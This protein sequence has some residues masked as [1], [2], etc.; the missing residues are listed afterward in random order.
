MLETLEKIA[1]YDNCEQ[2]PGRLFIL[3]RE[4]NKEGEKR[5]LPKRWKD[6]ETGNYNA[7]NAAEAYRHHKS[8]E[9]ICIIPGRL[10][11]FVVDV[12]KGKPYKLIRL[13]RP[14]FALHDGNHLFY[15]HPNDRKYGSPNGKKLPGPTVCDIRVDRGYV[16]L[17]NPEKDVKMILKALKALET[18]T[19]PPLYPPECVL[20]IFEFKKTETPPTEWDSR[21]KHIVQSA[22]EAINIRQIMRENEEGFAYNDWSTL[23]MAFHNLSNGCEQLRDDWIAWSNDRWGPHC[24]Y[25]HSSENLIAKWK[26]FDGY[27]D[28][29]PGIGAVYRI[30]RKYAPSFDPETEY[31]KQSQR[32]SLKNLDDY[33]TILKKN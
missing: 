10:G 11:F 32:D 3:L 28:E 31:D 30:T 13:G 8:G 24:I 12:D 17:H 14:R 26:N 27:V 15:C 4:D 19:I 9:D 23:S 22:M 7:W 18:G 2:Y 21:T 29:R 20:K 5:P 16:K 25:K 1:T 33:K 6:R